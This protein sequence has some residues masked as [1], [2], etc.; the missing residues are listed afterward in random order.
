[1][2]T[3]APGDDTAPTTLEDCQQEISQLRAAMSSRSVIDQAKGILIGQHGCTAEQAFEMQSAA[4]QRDNRKLRDVAGA[5]VAGAQDGVGW[6][7]AAPDP[8]ECSTAA[9]AH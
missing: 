1:M 5:V 3:C 2:T 6:R 9:V 7:R 8:P 4:S